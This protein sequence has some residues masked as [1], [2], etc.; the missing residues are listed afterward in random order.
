MIT[1][2]HERLIFLFFLIIFLD[3]KIKKKKLLVL[4]KTF[5]TT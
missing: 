3:F 1:F 5:S 4:E 2:V